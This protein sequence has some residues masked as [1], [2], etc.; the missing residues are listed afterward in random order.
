MTPES[1]PDDV[2]QSLL[3]LARDIY[4]QSVCFNG[5]AAKKN[6]VF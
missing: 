4:V 3:H 6:A 2:S 1:V 5:Q